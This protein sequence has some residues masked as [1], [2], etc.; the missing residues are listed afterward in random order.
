MALEARPPA[1]RGRIGPVTVCVPIASPV[2]HLKGSAAPGHRGSR[3]A[4]SAPSI[5][6]DCHARG[7]GAVAVAREHDDALDGH[8]RRTLA[9]AAQPRTRRHRRRRRPGGDTSGAAHPGGGQEDGE[10]LTQNIPYRWCGGDADEDVW[11]AQGG[12][13][14]TPTA[15]HLS[16]SRPG[17]DAGTAGAARAA[18]ECS[19]RAAPAAAA[20]VAA[21]AAGSPGVR[22]VRRSSCSIVASARRHRAAPSLRR[23]A[24]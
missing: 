8:R 21:A 16:L 13:R 2:A 14:R 19:A 6:V 4:G 9:E 15:P 3:R 22:A 11:E 1:S 18:P 10:A 5:K 17:A 20:V 12:F 24:S 23:C 7:G